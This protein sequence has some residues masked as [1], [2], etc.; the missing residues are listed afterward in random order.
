MKCLLNI[1]S[2]QR[3]DGTEDFIEIKTRGTFSL[4]DGNLK[5]KYIETDDEQVETFV[6]VTY[7]G[8][9][10]NIDRK[11][12]R[13]HSLITVEPGE[14]HSCAYST[15]YGMLMLGLYGKKFDYRVD[16]RGGII[17]L[18]YSIDINSAFSGENEITIEI[19]S[20]EGK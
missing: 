20:E 5:I 6:T 7:D 17:V 11:C 8:H 2:V 10:F 9:L 15:P 19:I 14:R 18:C 1:R 13:V 16:E 12:G 4:K 3:H